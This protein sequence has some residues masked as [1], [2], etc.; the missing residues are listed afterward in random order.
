[1]SPTIF[2]PI[3]SGLGGAI[4]GACVSG[5]FLYRLERRR[6]KFDLARRLFGYRYS[7]KGDGFSCAMNEVMAVFSDAKNVLE[8]MDHL[9]KALKTTEKSNVHEEAL[10]DFLKAVA[11]EA[12]LSQTTLDDNYFLE[13]FKGKD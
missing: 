7:I 6:L 9:F 10:T 1:M 2:L 12:K 8:K 5:W 11:K 4:I 13:I 3:L